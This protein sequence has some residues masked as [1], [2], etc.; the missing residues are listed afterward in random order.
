ME[1][2]FII[3]VYHSAKI[4][5]GTLIDAESGEAYLNDCETR[6]ED[7]SPLFHFIDPFYYNSQYFFG[8]ILATTEEA[9]EL[10]FEA[11]A[12]VVKEKAQKI[13]DEYAKEGFPLSDFDLK[14]YLMHVTE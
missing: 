10:D 6:N 5:V 13:A 12:R 7:W 9:T 8:E 11:I 14:V 1:W 2:R 4:G 3:D